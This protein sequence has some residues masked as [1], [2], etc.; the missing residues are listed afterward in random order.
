[1]SVILW[2]WSW[3]RS[4]KKASR[5][6]CWDHWD[7]HVNSSVLGLFSWRRGWITRININKGY[8]TMYT[9]SPPKF[10]YEVS[11]T[12]AWQRKLLKVALHLPDT[13]A[14]FNC[15]RKRNT[16]WSWGMFST[17]W[18]RAQCC[19]S[20]RWC[21]VD[22]ISGRNYCWRRSKEMRSVCSGHTVSNFTINI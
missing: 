14:C 20:L 18:I 3:F 11:I 6:W 2:S 4:R 15:G 5:M 1:M 8:K 7:S 16:P 22:S 10:Y 17:I 19:R 21:R 13:L 12:M 9:P